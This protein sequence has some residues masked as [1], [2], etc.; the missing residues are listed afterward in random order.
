[1]FVPGPLGGV[2]FDLRLGDF[3]ELSPQATGI[4]GAK[5]VAFSEEGMAVGLKGAVAL[6]ESCRDESL[7]EPDERLQAERGD[8]IRLV[9]PTPLSARVLDEQIE[10]SELVFRLPLTT[11][12][13]WVRSGDTWRR[14]SKY[15][16][17]KE[18]PFHTWLGQAQPAD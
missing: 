7:Y 10:F 11:G 16:P 13:F 5:Q 18:M 17:Q 4:I 14:Y 8:H 6:L 2:I 12:V 1:M 15:E 3:A 9:L